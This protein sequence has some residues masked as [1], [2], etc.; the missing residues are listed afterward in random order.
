MW[1]TIYGIVVNQRIRHVFLLFVSLYI[2]ILLLHYSKL[3]EL[4][5]NGQIIKRILIPRSSSDRSHNRDQK[6][7][8]LRT[9]QKNDSYDHE[10]TGFTK[11][12]D[13]LVYSVYLDT[14]PNDFDNQHGQ[15]ILRII[16]VMK[17]RQYP[18]P[19]IYCV[20]KDGDLIV[21]ST[22]YRQ[23]E[24][25]RKKYGACVLSCKI[26]QS[27]FE[28][29][30][31]SSLKTVLLSTERSIDPKNSAELAVFRPYPHYKYNFSICVPPLYGHL[32]II[33][34][35]EFIE[36]STIL[37]AEHVTLY[38]M[39]ISEELLRLLEHY[40][41]QGRVTVRM[42]DLNVHLDTEKQIWYHGQMAA[43]TDC[44]FSNIGMSRYVTFNDVDEF[45]I[46]YAFDK[47]KDMMTVLDTNGESIC[48]YK[49]QSIV[50]PPPSPDPP[51]D[52]N[53]LDVIMYLSTYTSTERTAK[54][55]GMR[56]KCMVKPDQVFEQGIHHISKPIW[57]DLNTVDVDQ[58]QALVHHYRK[59][60]K[61]FR[62]NQKNMKQENI[63][64]E[65][66]MEQLV[67][68][69]ADTINT[70]NIDIDG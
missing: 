5:N 24:D 31:L 30:E 32:S 17:I 13:I 41:K 21:R 10:N 63:V 50:F 34:V 48:G 49:F 27:Y 6:S 40:Q 14:R 60:S 68:M 15:A 62:I 26:P 35:I 39:D 2:I 44:L 45:I 7:M 1:D 29:V 57:A 69:V 16:T 37:G 52:S 55:S 46:P 59:P 22:L 47:W 3:D 36:L 8:S 25:H 28:N 64:V 67:I 43:I 54:A 4:R 61:S 58:K 70:L 65:K 33:K 12:G 51:P 23:V 66:Y 20:L 18:T 9:G 19:L 11:L 56:T 38:N 42:W 53:V